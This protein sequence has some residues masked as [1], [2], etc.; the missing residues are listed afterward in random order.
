MPDP[1]DG[2]VLPVRAGNATG[3]G[4]AG[5]TA[6]PGTASGGFAPALGAPTG[7]TMRMSGVEHVGNEGE[8]AGRNPGAL[9]HGDGRGRPV[10]APDVQ[11]GLW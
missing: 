5:S 2:V 9:R 4:P 7:G 8:P 11:G 6:T 10:Q 3:S 1:P